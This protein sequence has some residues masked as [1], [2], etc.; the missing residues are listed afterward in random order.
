M[1]RYFSIPVAFAAA[2]ND[3]V[4][5][6]DDRNI[7]DIQ[8]CALTDADSGIEEER[9]DCLVLLP[10]AA[11]DRAQEYLLLLLVQR[12]RCFLGEFFAGN[13]RFRRAEELEEMIDGGEIRVH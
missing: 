11:G 10:P 1:E 7:V 8:I 9:G 4:L 6:A 3:P 2:N 5:G 13:F 12:T